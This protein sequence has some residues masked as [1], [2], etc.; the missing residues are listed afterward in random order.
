MKPYGLH[1]QKQDIGIK[2]RKKKDGRIKLHC[3]KKGTKEPFVGQTRS[4]W[5]VAAV[6]RHCLHPQS[7][8]WH[9]C[10][11]NKIKFPSSVVQ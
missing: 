11:G 7:D 4:P 5:R 8:H 2:Q 3:H 10:N 9:A 1:I 6:Y